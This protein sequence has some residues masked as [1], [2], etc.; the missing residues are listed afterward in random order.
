MQLNKNIYF[1]IL[2]IIIIFITN[3]YFTYEESLIFGGRDGEFYIAIADAAPFFGENIE[4][5]KGERFIVPYLIGIISKIFYFESYNLF[6]FFSSASF[7]ICVYL[8][9][10]ILKKIN[11]NDNQIFISLGLLI[12]NPYLSRYFI[13]VPTSLMDITFI[14]SLEIII[15]AFLS[16]KKSL[17]YFGIFLSTMV[18]QNGLLILITFIFVKIYYR[19]KSK[20][21]IK[22]ILV[23]CLIYFFIFSI[24][25]I[26]A[27][28]SQGNESDIKNL[29]S[30]TLFGIFN[31][32]YSF[33]EFLKYILFPLLSFGPMILYLFYLKKMCLFDKN[34][35]KSEICLFIILLS[36]FIIGIA[37]VGGPDVTGKNLNRLS[38]FSYINLLF[39]INY[40]FNCKFLRS[41]FK[42]YKKF[43]LFLFF[44]LW[45]FHPTF[46]IFNFFQ[47]FKFIFV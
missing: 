9:Y 34:I 27:L 43:L 39:L 44:L 5:I 14:I 1:S 25:T 7:L 45:S 23:I 46:S 19:K 22:D 31:F 41:D 35:F 30:L 8:F 3:S 10:K 33:S 18:R 2:S 12:F 17:F 32:T 20:I 21:D 16:N 47:I 38:N 11:L 26:Y 6:R 42:I 4:Y 37:F 28:N 24:N 13:A 29:Y 36:M 15:L 40:L